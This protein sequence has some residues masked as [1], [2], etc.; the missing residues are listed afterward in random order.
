MLK[1]TV[2]A[3]CLALTTSVAMAANVGGTKSYES[4][5]AGATDTAIDFSRNN[6]WSGIIGGALA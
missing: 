5:L 4:Q 6:E 3:V 1:T 2:A